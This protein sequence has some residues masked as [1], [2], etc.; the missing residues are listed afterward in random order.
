MIKYYQEKKSKDF[1][2]VDTST[3]KYYKRMGKRE[4][5]GRAVCINNTPSS[6]CTTGISLKFLKNRCKRVDALKVPFS[7]KQ[8]F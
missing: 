7:Y 2:M 8:Y 1:L 4:L 6:M 5:E 3:R